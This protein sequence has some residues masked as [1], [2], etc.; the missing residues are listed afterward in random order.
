MRYF[1]AAVLVCFSF[2]C[3]RQDAI[4]ID[5]AQ[6]AAFAPLP[7]SVPSETNPATPAKIELGWRLYYEKQLSADG[8]QS[9]NTCHL[10]DAYGVDGEPVST[11]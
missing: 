8:S 11:G 6:L 1:A 7:E 3:Q 4:T 2:A 5:S 10:L 9:C